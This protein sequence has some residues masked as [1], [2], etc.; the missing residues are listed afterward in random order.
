M[1]EE[2]F[3]APSLRQVLTALAILVIFFGLAVLFGFFLFKL[4]RNS[5]NKTRTKLDDII[6]SVVQKPI[7][8]IIIL[9]GFYISALYLPL[10]TTFR[11]N[12]SKGFYIAISLLAIFV[13]LALLDGLARWS[14]ST[15]EAKTEGGLTRRL[16]WI[17]RV[18]MWIAGVIAAVAVVLHTL[19]IE[20]T[21]IASWMGQNGWRIAFII[22]ISMV[23]VVAIAHLIPR[24]LEK[25]VARRPG[26][27]NE[28]L[29]KRANT[30]SRVTVNITQI[31]ILSIAAF[32]VLSELQIDIA[33][34]L[35]GA[36][37]VG[38]AI[39][40]GAQSL[41][42]DLLAGLFV[43][44]E[45]QYHVGDVVKIADISGLVEDINLR[46]TILRDLDGVVHIVPNGEIR[47]AS[48][49]TKEWS[50]VNLNVSVGYGED[51]DHAIE[52]INKVGKELA[53]D[54]QWAPLI[55][56]P[57]QV[58]RVDK[59]GE[60]GVDIKILGDTKPM[61][62]W[63]VMGELRKRLK[64]SFDREGIEIPWPHTKIYFGNSPSFIP[65]AKD[66]AK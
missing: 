25:A 50:R 31:V 8:T 64:E 7:I 10:G 52:V 23:V 66:Q 24:A 54:T 22:I 40:F 5:T 32:M 29:K 34:I 48:N 60:S 61:R 27:P 3:G 4:A 63:D 39:G 26:E 15:L 58:L 55:L 36:G 14:G 20:L 35:A 45:S 13:L 49:F 2:L 56:K 28:E 46:R 44:V 47:V 12:L 1:L 59:L 38:L 53:D 43:I 16:L 17:S 11:L 6:L 41:V 9:A 18:L 62:Q 51:L 42:K 30:L 57:P 37:V 65:G 19:S 21:P 33:P